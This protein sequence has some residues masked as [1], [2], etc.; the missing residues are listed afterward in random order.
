MSTFQP[1]AAVTGDAGF[2]RVGLPLL[3]D[4]SDACAVGRAL[5]A[6]PGMR[7]SSGRRG[8][9]PVQDFWFAP[10][11]NLLNAVEHDAGEARGGTGDC[12]PVHAEWAHD[13]ART[14]LD[15]RRREEAARV[16]SG[17]P[18]TLPVRTQW[19]A[20]T[21]LR[22]PDARG[23]EQYERT[24]W[25]RG[26]ATED[27]SLREIW[28]P[29]IDS[30]KRDRTP[31]ETAAAAAVLA[32]GVPVR[33]PYNAR[34]RELL[35]VQG[36]QSAELRRSRTLPRRVRVIGIGLGDGSVEVLADWDAEEAARQFGMHAKDRM[37]VVVDGGGA[38]RAGS[39]C[40][41]CKALSGCTGIPRAPDLLGVPAPAR[42]RKR[43]SVSASDLRVHASCPA[44][45]HLTRVLRLKDGQRENAAI[46]RGR[47]VDDW[48][49]RQHGSL[50]RT[51]CRRVPLP[52]ALPGLAA[53]ELAPALAMLR[54]H[55]ARCPLDGLPATETVLPQWR[56]AAYDPGLDT[57][58]VAD[59][60]L[61]YTDRGGWVWR[62]TKTAGERFRTG[63]S[64]LRQYPQ[65]ALTV[66]LMAAGVPGGE[67]RRCRIELEILRTDGGALEEID[68]FDADT[69]AE[70][71]RIVAR[72]AAAWAVD[73][74]YAPAPVSPRVCGE[75][76]V[77]RWCATGREVRSHASGV[78]AQ[79]GPDSETRAMEG[80]R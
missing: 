73:E 45:F 52:D 35:P 76:E 68:P 48:L 13:A 58:V 46:R 30:V 38:L 14:Y 80:V 10:V 26:Y 79:A 57:V 32:A 40:V 22:Q 25:G 3:R 56:L 49:N 9:G 11:E 50:P 67:A 42:P 47:A 64:P 74:A 43:R 27:G 66:V 72:D 15:A 71:R 70:A 53:E 75:C 39:D 37:S 5:R 60:D 1:S 61:L 29:S 41:G 31:A 2:V 24:V 12:H 36:E 23:V 78:R 77:G 16:S 69:L 65:L 44:R 54:A 63:V 7:S 28:I 17:H 51:S 4:E 33:P 62:E 8:P 19:I 21:M 34:A 59:P 55:R 20:I 6:R 18:P